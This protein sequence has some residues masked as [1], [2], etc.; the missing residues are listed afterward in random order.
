MPLLGCAPLRNKGLRALASRGGKPRDPHRAL[1]CDQAL[2]R[3]RNRTPDRARGLRSSEA[4]KT[5]APHAS[6]RLAPDPNTPLRGRGPRPDGAQPWPPRASE[7]PLGPDASRARATV[8]WADT[9]SLCPG[10]AR[11]RLQPGARLRV[12]DGRHRSAPPR[13]PCRSLRPYAAAGR[14]RGTRQP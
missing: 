14:R 8:M 11:R 1:G 5:A 2:E 7:T 6:P 13:S 4:V 10:P 3:V 9:T 12:P